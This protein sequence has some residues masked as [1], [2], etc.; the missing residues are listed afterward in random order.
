MFLTFP[1]GF[2]RNVDKLVQAAT[3]YFVAQ[4]VLAKASTEVAI[5]AKKNLVAQREALEKLD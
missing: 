5:E 4:A 1:G 2:E 3:D